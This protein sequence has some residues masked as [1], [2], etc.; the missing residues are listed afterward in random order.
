MCSEPMLYTLEA[1]PIYSWFWRCPA[2]REQASPVVR[3]CACAASMPTHSD[4][5]MVGATCMH[6]MVSQ[7]GVADM[8][9]ALSETHT[10]MVS[11][12]SRLLHDHGHHT[13]T[14]PCWLRALR[15]LSKLRVHI[16]RPGPGRQLPRGS[17]PQ[18]TVRGLSL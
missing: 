13:S 15:G 4:I 10:G 6:T 12:H 16:V 17:G 18:P 2:G 1:K 8:V 7:L 11:S 9:W 14:G 3:V 5:S